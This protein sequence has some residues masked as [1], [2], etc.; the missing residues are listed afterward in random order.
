MARS[1]IRNR[2]RM[3]GSP[4]KNNQ[5]RSLGLTIGALSTIPVINRCREAIIRKAAREFQEFAHETG[6]YR[7][8]RVDTQHR[9]ARS[10]DHLVGHAADDAF[11]AAEQEA[12]D[13][14]VSERAV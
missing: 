11:L 13:R 7:G 2:V 10:T 14:D 5:G 6:R 8:N 3:S 4:R 1:A 9:R 12:D